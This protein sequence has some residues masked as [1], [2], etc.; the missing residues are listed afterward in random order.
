MI[1]KNQNA[2]PRIQATR[3]VD[4]KEYRTQRTVAAIAEIRTRNIV[5]E[6]S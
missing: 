1:W 6:Q 5:P 2:N 4:A 3:K